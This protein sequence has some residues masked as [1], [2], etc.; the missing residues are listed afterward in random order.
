MAIVHYHLRSHFFC[1]EVINTA[2]PI[3]HIRQQ[4][5]LESHP[6]PLPLRRLGVRIFFQDIGDNGAIYHETFW[7]LQSDTLDL[8]FPERMNSLVN[9]ER[10]I[11]GQV[12]RAK[13]GAMPSQ[14]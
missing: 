10:V 1:R 9:L 13:G 7:H 11:A 6:F 2:G 5:R 8:V 3:S 4:E 14:Y 12:C